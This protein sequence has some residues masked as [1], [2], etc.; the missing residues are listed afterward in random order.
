MVDT[1]ANDSVEISIIPILLLKII[2]LI[3][4]WKAKTRKAMVGDG[5]RLLLKLQK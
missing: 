2:L 3:L 4:D 5:L 1:T